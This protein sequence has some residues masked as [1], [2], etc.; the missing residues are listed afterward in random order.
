MAVLAFIEAKPGTPRFRI[1]MSSA[2]PASTR[3]PTT[4]AVALPAFDKDRRRKKE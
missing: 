3:R 1:S 4:I 2:Q